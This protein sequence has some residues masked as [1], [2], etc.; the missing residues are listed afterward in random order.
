[1]FPLQLT[2]AAGGGKK[3]VGWRVF[4]HEFAEAHQD[5]AP[6]NTHNTATDTVFFVMPPVSVAW[7]DLNNMKL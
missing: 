5:T 4:I 7:L 3:G 6:T 2:A 1:M